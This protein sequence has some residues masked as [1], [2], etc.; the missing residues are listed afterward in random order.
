MKTIIVVACQ[1]PT[2]EQMGKKGHVYQLV[3]SNSKIIMGLWRAGKN[4]KIKTKKTREA[5]VLQKWAK[6]P[7]QQQIRRYHIK[8]SRSIFNLQKA[9]T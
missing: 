7:D 1:I 5:T 9:L 3:N 2:P 6:G 8:K 4:R